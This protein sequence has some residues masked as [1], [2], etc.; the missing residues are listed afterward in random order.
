VAFQEEYLAL[1]KGKQLSTIVNLL[2]YVQNGLMWSDSC[3]QYAEF[4]PYDVRFPII[5][6]RRHR[7]IKLTVKVTS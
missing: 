6:P 1:S 4:L 2:A 7:V 5:L 3:L